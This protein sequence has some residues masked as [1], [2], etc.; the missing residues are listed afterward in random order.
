MAVSRIDGSIDEETFWKMQRSK[1]L[2]HAIVGYCTIGF[3]SGLFAKKLKEEGFKD[4]YNG[5]GVVLW[6][7]DPLAEPLVRYSD[8][9]KKKPV[10]EVHVYGKDWDLAKDEYKTEKFSS[11]ASVTSGMFGTVRSIVSRMWKHTPSKTDE[12]NKGS[13]N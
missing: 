9:G 5:E 8:D 12:K 13:E 6:T 11:V 7:H 4:V 10:K 3:R 1:I 2:D